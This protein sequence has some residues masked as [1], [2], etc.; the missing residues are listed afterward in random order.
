MASFCGKVKESCIYF[1]HSTMPDKTAKM[2][3]DLQKAM[4]HAD[5]WEKRK[6]SIPGIFLV[7]MPDK[8]LRVRLEFNPPDDAG[9]PTKR[10]GLYFDDAETVQAAR[11][12]F[13]DGRLED[14]VT[15]V[16]K[17]NGTTK[18]KP[19]GDEEVFEI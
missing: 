4:V 7:K 19:A 17:L 10:K 18:R 8:E 16:Q 12:A 13:S 6:T 11:K 2:A 3:E 9:N 14:L 15:A 5:D 1:P